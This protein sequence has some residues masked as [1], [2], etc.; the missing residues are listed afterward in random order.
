MVDIDGAYVYSAVRLI[1]TGAQDK[2]V[3]VTA[4]PN[5]VVNDLRVTVPQTWQ[6]KQ[7]SMDLFNM[8]GQVVKH[9]ATGNASQTEV[10]NVN[11]MP[12]GMYILKA[13]NGT[14]TASQKIVKSK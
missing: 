13:S 5:P 2:N 14:E 4:Y 11:D 12:V 3:T 1:R 8:N 9:F 10:I 7:V 6:S